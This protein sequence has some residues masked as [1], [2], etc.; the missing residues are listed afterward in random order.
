MKT[1]TDWTPYLDDPDSA[2][3]FYRSAIAAQ[4]LRALFGAYTGG[5][6]NVR[7]LQKHTGFM[8]CVGRL[9]SKTN[10]WTWENW[11]PVIETL[12][13]P[14]NLIWAAF[15][16]ESEGYDVYVG[17]LPRGKHGEARK[18]SL[19]HAGAA[20]V[21]LDFHKQE[22]EAAT[23]QMAEQAN[24]DIIVHSGGGL[25]L[26][27]LAE[28]PIDLTPETLA[29][30]EK[31]MKYRQAKMGADPTHDATRIL[32]LPGTANH[33]QEAPRPVRLLKCP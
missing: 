22:S 18:A 21:E 7:C 1:R 11:Y 30:F 13:N 28:T 33:K 20:W 9:N 31:S 29:A 12:A 17:V 8:P 4:Y 5:W 6:I 26:Y 10:V 15:L 16:A 27:F 23:I 19:Y 3:F 25:H 2:P 32:R 14:D 24:P